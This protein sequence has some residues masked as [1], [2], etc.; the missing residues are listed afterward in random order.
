M[1]RRTLRARIVLGLLGY[2]LLLSAMIFGFGEIISGNEEFVIQH[3]LLDAEIDDFIH[4]R[5]RDPHYPPPENSTLR[6]YVSTPGQAE[7]GVPPELRTLPQ[8]VHDE[9][10]VAGRSVTAVVRDV[11][12]ERIYMT[13]DLTQQEHEE[14]SMFLWELLLSALGA[15]ILSWAIWWLSGRLLRPVS[16]LVKAIDAVSADVRDQR[17]EVTADSTS[18][19]TTIARAMNRYVERMD[20]F[21]LRERAFIDSVSHELRTPIA[22]IAGAAEIM[23]ADAAVPESSRP[24][25]A[26]IQRTATDVGQLITALL[27]LAKTPSR[28]RASGEACSLEQLVPDIVNAHEHMRRNRELRVDV[29]ALSPSRIEVPAQI[30]TVAIANILRNAIENT[31]RGRVGVSIQPAGVVRIEDS[32][33]G[34]SPEEIAR[35]YTAQARQDGSMAGYG[36]GLQ[37]IRHI[38]EHLG[39]TLEIASRRDL[40]TV[41]VLDMRASLAR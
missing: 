2:T 36:I 39:W 17:I 33:R 12:G 6:T 10:A 1:V 23:A 20:G 11:G 27:V 14:Y 28:L 18:E 8:G 38:S 30:V 15:G 21:V 19:I 40:G 41:V 32:G 13:F 5:A 29:G 7:T 3:S 9:I 24:P 22:V 4:D 37:L 34:M 25:L 16:D 35:I 31:D 26:R